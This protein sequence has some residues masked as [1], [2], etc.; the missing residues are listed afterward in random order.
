MCAGGFESK[1]VMAV[2]NSCTFALISELTVAATFKKPLSVAELHR[3][4]VEWLREWKPRA[5]FDRDGAIR[6]DDRGN[7]IFSEPVSTPKGL[8]NLKLR[9]ERVN[10][11]LHLSYFWF[12]R[13]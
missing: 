4:E 13:G 12:A 1:G 8:L 3:N 10:D 11:L 7:V 2:P 5:L 6:R 9:N